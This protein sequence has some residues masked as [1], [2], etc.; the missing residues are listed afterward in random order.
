MPL[1]GLI[2]NLQT[3]VNLINN[4]QRDQTEHIKIFIGNNYTFQLQIFISDDFMIWKNVFPF[5]SSTPD[6]FYTFIL[7]LT[8]SRTL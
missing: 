5:Y 8:L 4:E 3:A 7:F 6:F 2:T 1:T